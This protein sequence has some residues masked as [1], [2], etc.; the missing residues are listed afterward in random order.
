MEDKGSASF[1][2]LDTY[3]EL[4]LIDQTSQEWDRE[5]VP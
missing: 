1:L 3:E 2:T 4:L 5:V